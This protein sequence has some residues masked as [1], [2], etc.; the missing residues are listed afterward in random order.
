MGTR[1]V[2]E[3][4]YKRGEEGGKGLVSNTFWG[5]VRQG[6]Y[7]QRFITGVTAAKTAMIASTSSG[8]GVA[9]T[10]FSVIGQKS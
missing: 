10:S 9:W 1:V 7:M 6:A 3:V 8:P 2:G 4:D 5:S